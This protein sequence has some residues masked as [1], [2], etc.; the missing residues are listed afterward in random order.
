MRSAAARALA[1]AAAAAAAPPPPLARR[2]LLPAR[3]NHPRRQFSHPCPWPWSYTAPRA[4][5]VSGRCHRRGEASPCRYP[6]RIQIEILPKALSPGREGGKHGRRRAL[7]CLVGAGQAAGRVQA[8]EPIAL[9]TIWTVKLAGWGCW[10]AACMGGRLR[11]LSTARAVLTPEPWRS[12]RTVGL[13][14]I[15]FAARTSSRCNPAASCE[16]QLP[17][18]APSRAQ[19]AALV[20]LSSLVGCPCNQR[21]QTVAC[22]SRRPPSPCRRHRTAA[23]HGAADGLRAGAG[24]AHG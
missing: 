16:R 20:V 22:A 19:P 11:G 2:P 23:S 8:G 15:L 6:L 13:H 5:G 17:A 10:K 9:Q 12:D 18:A 21:T 4:S 14:C 3:T 1:Q 24:A 7:K